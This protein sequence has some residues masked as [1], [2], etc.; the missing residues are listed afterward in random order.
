MVGIEAR[1]LAKIRTGSTMLG[2]KTQSV[3]LVVD[4]ENKDNEKKYRIFL[5]HLYRKTFQTLRYE[6]NHSIPFFFQLREKL[7]WLP[8]KPDLPETWCSTKKRRPEKDFNE[9]L[10]LQDS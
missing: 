7:I 1:T 5:T 4:V 6:E 8:E 3:M 9:M 10:A 2:W